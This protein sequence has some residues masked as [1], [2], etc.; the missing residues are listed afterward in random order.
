MASSEL[1]NE[2]QPSQLLLSDEEK[3]V[4]ELYDRLRQIQ[5][6]LALLKAQKN[7]SPG[8]P[9][10]GNVEEAQNALLKSRAKYV[11]RNNIADCV[12]MAN[13]ILQ[14]VHNGINASPIEKDLLPLLIARD[15][16]ST[17][18]AQQTT[19]LRQTLDQLMEIESQSLQISRENVQL[20]SEVLKL[21]EETN[22][23]K[24]APIADPGH[25]EEIAR[26]E[27]EVRASRKRWRIMKGTAS[28]IVAGSG[29]D[30]ARD[31][32]LKSIVLDEEE[33]V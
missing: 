13:P 15:D 32:R 7:Y 3:R 2:V 28:A 31:D 1:G 30:W 17:T 23:S 21:A 27:A 11:L 5:L 19:D 29:V 6:E 26:L 12:M 10:S 20:A 18:L 22:R 25:A 24:T 16:S 14:A 4:L 33:D 9:A 8:Q